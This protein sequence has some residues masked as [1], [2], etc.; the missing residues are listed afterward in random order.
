ME[1]CGKQ[2][3]LVLP[4]PSSDLFFTKKAKANCMLWSASC[5]IETVPLKHFTVS[6]S[7]CF[8]PQNVTI[9]SLSLHS[10]NNVFRKC[11]P[12]A[13][14]V[15]ALPPCSLPGSHLGA[16]S[17]QCAQL[18]GP[19]LF[20]YPVSQNAW[21]RDNTVHLQRETCNTQRFGK[22]GTGLTSMSLIYMLQ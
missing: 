1:Q 5:I 22:A 21:P 14:C 13:D 15:A 17:R 6:L 4:L 19:F 9:P 3:R 11:H 20:W 10:W 2:L 18:L 12:G 8:L 7:S 16:G